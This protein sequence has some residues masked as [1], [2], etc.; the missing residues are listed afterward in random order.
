MWLCGCLSTQPWWRPYSV[1]CTVTS[2]GTPATRASLR[3]APATS[4]SWECTRSTSRPSISSAPAARMSSF[5][6]STHEM[7]ASRSSLGKSGSRTRWTVT[8]CRSSSVERG[9]AC[10]ASCSFLALAFGDV[11]SARVSRCTSCSCAT[12]CSASLRTC[13]ASPPSTIGGYSQERIRTRGGTRR[14]ADHIVAA[15]M[16]VPILLDCDPGHDDAVAILLAAGN[17][18]I[19]LRAI[20]TVA[21]NCPLDLATRNARRVAALAGLD[22]PIAAGAA[23]P[24]AGELVTAPDIHGETGLDGPDL[25]EE[26]PLDERTALELMVATLEASEEPITLMPTGPLT[27]VAALLEARP[28]LHGRIREIVIM[29]GSTA[30]GNT[31]P[32]AEFNIWVDPESA[33]VVFE[34]GLPLTMIGLNLTHQAGATREVLE[35]VQALPG[36]PARAVADWM[37]FFG[38]RYERVFGRFAP[39]VHDPC[40]VALLIDPE[41]MTLTDTFVA[42]ETEGRWTRGMTVVD[43]HGRFGR[44][45]NARVAHELDAP[46]FWDLVIA[47]L[48][49]L[50]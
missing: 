13:R 29:G 21:G 44:E 48:E 37:V 1:A 40:T 32:A 45:P 30:P 46:R 35:R 50:A 20:T 11:T 12:S 14:G 7:N 38:S 4:Q 34:S 10:Q 23:G 26:A 18:A 16:P 17:D 36:A 24:R 2:Q 43:L 8:P 15:S 19:D 5:M 42:V 41:V 31:T 47:A 27:N 33:A 39:P 28:D 6:W 49:R 9:F 3:A 22:V 25:T